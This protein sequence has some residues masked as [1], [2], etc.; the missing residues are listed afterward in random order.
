MRIARVKGTIIMSQ[1]LPQLR[2]GQ[3]LLV[4]VLDGAALS[5]LA[6]NAPRHTAMPEALVVFDQLGAGP[7]QIIAVSEGREAAM[8]FEPGFMPI[9]AY[10]AAILDVLDLN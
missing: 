2:A 3:W 4:E 5:G 6:K 8:P 1:G 10:N 7:G 9:D